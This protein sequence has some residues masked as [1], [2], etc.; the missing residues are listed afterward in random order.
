M[1]NPFSS[2]RDPLTGVLVLTRLWCYQDP[3]AL[4]QITIARVR[5]GI[6][7]LDKHCP[8]WLDRLN[9]P[10]FKESFDW[11]PGKAIINFAFGCHRIGA[12]IMDIEGH[13]VDYGFGLPYADHLE[14]MTRVWGEML[15]FRIHGFPLP[16][17]LNEFASVTQ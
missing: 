6:A 2:V 14:V 11:D 1:T 16:D 4:L 3:A 9:H 13:T 8:D 17:P 15:T 7:L 5:R 10:K 12:G